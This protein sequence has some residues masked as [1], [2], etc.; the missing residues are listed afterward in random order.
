[1]NEAINSKNS[2][3]WK[4]AAE[5][6]YQSL[7]KNN[8]WELVE[9]PKENNVITCKWIFKVKRRADG[10][11]D[12]Y[13]SRL[14]AQ[15]YSQEEGEDYNDTFAPVAR[16]S[17]IRS[18]LAITNQLDLEVHQ[19][20]VKTAY[21]NGNLEHEIYMEQPEGYVDKNQADLVCRLR[22]SL[23]SL[24]QSARCWN[25]TTDSFLKASGYIQS[26]AYMLKQ[27]TKMERKSV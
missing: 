22:K 6:E 24:K 12:R 8:T 7:L 27:K 23:N 3:Y 16:Y 21:L 18:I 2:K 11:V 4:E 15:G 19:M 9:R 17:S 5:N 20:D 14:V 1:M 13:K 26:N 25:I 10:T